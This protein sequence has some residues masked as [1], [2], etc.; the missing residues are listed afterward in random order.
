M[1]CHDRR[2]FLA[3][4]SETISAT[5]ADTDRNLAEFFEEEIRNR[6]ATILKMIREQDKRRCK[7]K[8][9][10]ATR[11]EQEERDRLKYSSELAFYIQEAGVPVAL[12][13]EALVDPDKAWPRI[14]GSRRGRTL[15][16]R[17]R[18]WEAYRRWLIACRGY[19]WP[20]EVKDLIDYIEERVSQGCGKS[21]P[22]TFQAALTVLEDVGGCLESHKLSRDPLWK[23][24]LKAWQVHLKKGTPV[25][26]K[27]KPYTVAII[28]SLELAVVSPEIPIFPRHRLGGSHHDLVH[29]EGRRHPKRCP[30]RH[31][32]QPNRLESQHEKDENNRP[33]QT[34]WD[35]PGICETRC[36]PHRHRLVASR[37]RPLELCRVLLRTGLLRPRTQ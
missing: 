12:Q 1:Q 13:V 25:T 32:P 14:F 6:P 23:A 34:A 3:S 10:D 4:A 24:H 17:A 36:Q 27:A 9:E 2:R 31:Q 11:S 8:A 28:V 19:V 33:R 20:K 15:R 21:V 5:Q 30:I 16:N 22:T 37:P 29:H 26:K 7:L 35:S 18:T